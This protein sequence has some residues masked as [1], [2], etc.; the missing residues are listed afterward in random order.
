MEENFNNLKKSFF[1]MLSTYI[2]NKNELSKYDTLIHMPPK[3]FEA[4]FSL[5]FLL[6]PKS[7]FLIL[8]KE[9]EVKFK[10]SYQ[11]FLSFYEKKILPELSYDIKKDLK[12]FPTRLENFNIIPLSESHFRDIQLFKDTINS[13]ILS[14]INNF[15]SQNILIDVTGGTKLHSIILAN[16]ASIHNLSYCYLMVDES[17]R[18]DGISALAGTERIYIQQPEYKKISYLSIHSFPILSIFDSHISC[19]YDGKTIFSKLNIKPDSFEKVKNLFDK[20]SQDYAVYLNHNLISMLEE[21]FAE[22]IKMIR[23]FF[24]PD[25][26]SSIES[27]MRESKIFAISLSNKFWNFPFEFIFNDFNDFILLR[28]IPAMNL[29]ERK[30]QEIKDLNGKDLQ[31][32]YSKEKDPKARY[33]EA[34]DIGK[35]EKLS[36]LKEIKKENK[37][38]ES[39]S[40]DE[41]V[42]LSDKES[43]NIINE[44]N[45]DKI[46]ILVALLSSDDYM[47]NQY[48]ELL[49]S[50]SS[51]NNLS[52]KKLFLPS[53]DEFLYLL[54]ECDIAHIICHG[55]LKNGTFGLMMENLVNKNEK[56][57]LILEQTDFTNIKSPDFLF[58]SA[59]SSL[60]IN[61]DWDKTIYYELFKNGCKTIIGTHWAVPQKEALSVSNLFYK[62]F[63]SGQPVG[64]ALHLAL[65]EI[66][67]QFLS[68]NYYFI[69]NHTARI[70]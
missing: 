60:T 66:N 42:S 45:S 41:I 20:Y 21:D 8:T 32:M 69:G 12:D 38:K 2:E 44:K 65:K 58:I 36:Y 5:Y 29:T 40:F 34:N 18:A 50:F 26:L 3:R 13:I 28:S 63:L 22:L 4:T 31:V 1:K 57:K 67:N 51:S 39:N 55:I 27:F 19:F 59:C 61:L 30:D 33:S 46:K 49:N 25:F 53:K 15:N 70:I 16:L 23:S 24:E 37:E 64:M 54:Q 6:R 17:K 10:Q 43:K 62:N 35:I 48:N 56:N 14:I 52:L 11:E 7:F 9:V 47:K 68:R